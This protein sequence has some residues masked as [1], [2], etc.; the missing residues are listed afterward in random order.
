MHF[1]VSELWFSPLKTLFS[2]VE[3][4]ASLILATEF[5]GLFWIGMGR[6]TLNFFAHRKLRRLDPSFHQVLLRLDCARLF[7]V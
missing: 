2:E 7:L 1:G 6:E 5:A 3:E 4:W